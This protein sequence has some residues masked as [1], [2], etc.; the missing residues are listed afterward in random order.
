MEEVENSTHISRQD[1]KDAAARAKANR[2]RV[3]AKSRADANRKRVQ[4]ESHLY[5][6]RI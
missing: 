5:K 2:I 6:K 1:R 4:K 3:Q